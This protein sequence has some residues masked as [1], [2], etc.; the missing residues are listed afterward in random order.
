[1]G[2]A[3]HHGAPSLGDDVLAREE[4]VVRAVT[5]AQREALRVRAVARREHER[6]AVGGGLAWL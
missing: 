2:D 5:A 4:E 6:R 1:M 3:P